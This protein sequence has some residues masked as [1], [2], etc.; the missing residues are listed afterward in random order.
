MITDTQ[1]VNGIVDIADEI[2]TGQYQEENMEQKTLQN[3][4]RT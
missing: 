3:I 4:L 1:K 2:K